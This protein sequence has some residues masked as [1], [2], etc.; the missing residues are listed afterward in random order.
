MDVILTV[1]FL[2]LQLKSYPT[3]EIRDERVNDGPGLRTTS[4]IPSKRSL[5]QCGR[6]WPPRLSSLQLSLTRRPVLHLR[7]AATH[8]HSIYLI[9]CNRIH[10]VITSSAEHVLSSLIHRSNPRR[11]RSKTRQVGRIG[12]TR[13]TWGRYHRSRDP[14]S[15]GA[16][17][18]DCSR[19]AA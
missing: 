4:R 19:S 12:R 8:A 18:I 10:T 9:V 5:P 13:S 2:H 14:G 7:V 15:I 16:V 17:K 1:H 6:P 11:S 3:T